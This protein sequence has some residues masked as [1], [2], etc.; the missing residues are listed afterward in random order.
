M[1][2]RSMVRGA[3]GAQLHYRGDRVA[4]CDQAFLRQ[5]QTLKGGRVTL[6][7]GDIDS[8]EGLWRIPLFDGGEAGMTEEVVRVIQGTGIQR[9]VITRFD[10]ALVVLRKTDLN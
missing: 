1:A 10:D 4:P 9:L 6:A 8:I 2:S 7:E 3:M 5:G